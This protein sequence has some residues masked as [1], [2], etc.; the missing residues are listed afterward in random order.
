MIKKKFTVS[1]QNILGHLRAFWHKFTIFTDM[2]NKFDSS[3]L[4][5]LFLWKRHTVNITL[6]FYFLGINMSYFQRYS[7]VLFSYFYSFQGILFEDAPGILPTKNGQYVSVETASTDKHLSNARSPYYPFPIFSLRVIC[8]LY[9]AMHIH[10][11][12]CLLPLSLAL[13][14]SLSL[15]LSVCMCEFVCEGESA[16]RR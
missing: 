12:I 1:I 9:T 3:L 5:F 15:S 10:T 13:S 8:S 7:S 16:C 2:K 6:T 14:L 11:H 4:Y